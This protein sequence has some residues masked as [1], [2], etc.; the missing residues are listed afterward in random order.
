MF[1]TKRYIVIICKGD[2]GTDEDVNVYA[3]KKYLPIHRVECKNVTQRT[4]TIRRKS[5]AACD[6]ISEFCIKCA[7]KIETW[8]NIILEYNISNLPAGIYL[9]RG[10]GFEN[11][12][13]LENEKYVVTNLSLRATRQRH[14]DHTFFGL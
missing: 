6:I 2:G 10:N 3:N 8:R 13:L 1:L 7:E 14:V 12:T 9:H 11:T 4:S 5:M